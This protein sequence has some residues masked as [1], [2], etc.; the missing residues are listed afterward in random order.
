MELS[1]CPI[2]ELSGQKN[3]YNPDNNYDDN[4]FILKLKMRLQAVS[5]SDNLEMKK[6]LKSGV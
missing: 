1:P 2:Y 3:L 6:I 4:T 5:S